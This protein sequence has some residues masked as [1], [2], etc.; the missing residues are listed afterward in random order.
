[1]KQIIDPFQRK[2]NY[3][4]LSVTDRCDFRCQYCMPEK[5][6]FLPKKDILSLEELYKLCSCFISM[7]IKKIRITGG[8]PLVRKDII[9]LFWRL[10]PFIENKHL[11][12]LTLTT[13]GSQLSKYAYELYDTGVR[14]INISMDTLKPDKFKKIT[15]TGDLDNVLKG[16]KIAKKVGFKIKINTVALKNIN[17]DELHDLINW[18]GNEGFDITFIEVMPMGSFE[19]RNRLGQY[20]SLKDLKKEVEKKWNLINVPLNT[21]GPAKYSKILQT[22]QNIGFIS[23]LSNNFCENCNRIRI[24]CKGEL[25]TC[26]GQNGVTDLKPAIRN[27]G[28]NNHLLVKSIENSISKKPK[29]HD[30][31]YDDNALKGKL[32]RFMSHTGG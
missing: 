7:G 32:D 26:L 6:K 8:E 14:R 17:D 3:L 2:I 31:N 16:I 21:G 22:E 15:R 12:E 28:K 29:G 24:T 20:W 13:N 5:M 19:D 1:M 30:F 18:C 4:R 11:K 10:S 25:F 27:P 9:K 23:P